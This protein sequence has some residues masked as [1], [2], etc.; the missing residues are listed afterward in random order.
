MRRSQFYL[1]LN[2]QYERVR[3]S[4]RD[5]LGRITVRVYQKA[6]GVARGHRLDTCFKHFMKN[7]TEQDTLTHP[8]D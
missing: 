5:K 8:D 6:Q 3:S 1:L 7:E 4:L 2:S